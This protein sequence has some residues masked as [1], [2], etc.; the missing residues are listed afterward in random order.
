M[1]DH[2]KWDNT[3]HRQA[4]QDAKREVIFF[5]PGLSENIIINAALEVGADDV[6]IYDYGEIDVYTR[7]E[8]FREVKDG[9]E[10]TGLSDRKN[11]KAILASA[12]RPCASKWRFSFRR[13]KCAASLSIIC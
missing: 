2:S 13:R 8:A 7:P 5:A 11:W 10:S 4:A 1:A 3:K 9:L 6:I 12:S